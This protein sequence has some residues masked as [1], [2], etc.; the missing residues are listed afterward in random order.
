MTKSF[1]PAA[2][3]RR[4]T[5]PRIRLNDPACPREPPTVIWFCPDCPSMAIPPVVPSTLTTS[6][7]VPV[8]SPVVMP[9]G[10]VLSGVS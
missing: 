7:P 5:G 9:P 1:E 2:S 6:E 10:I 3:P 8:F 4:V